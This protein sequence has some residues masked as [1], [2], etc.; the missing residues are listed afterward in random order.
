MA[1]S[2]GKNLLL[3]IPPEIRNEI[4]R[5]L[6]KRDSQLHIRAPSYIHWHK[7]EQTWRATGILYVF[8]QI[9]DEAITIFFEY[10]TF[11]VSNSTISP[12]WGA[13]SKAGFEAFV[14]WIPESKRRLIRN[15][16]LKVSVY[17]AFTG[18]GVGNG[19]GITESF[20]PRD[21]AREMGVL[22]LDV[23]GKEKLL[24]IYGAVSS[25]VVKDDGVVKLLQLHT[26]SLTYGQGREGLYLG[27][28]SDISAFRRFYEHIGATMR[29]LKNV[30]LY[31]SNEEEE[32]DTDFIAP[33]KEVAKRETVEG[34]L[35]ALDHF[36]TMC[37][38]ENVSVRDQTTRSLWEF[39]MFAD[40]V[41]ETTPVQEV[42]ELF[43]KRKEESKAIRFTDSNRELS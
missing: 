7:I 11:V 20:R 29:G 5:L 23:N 10:N 24:D 21:K 4:Y 12:C 14:E 19:I 32:S 6:L 22:G 38:V 34:L 41:E 31:C 27:T 17:R 3:S 26:A 8:K 35:N 13:A 18:I 30:T 43:E 2:S 33:D 25:G 36:E 1:K 9:H 40:A 28:A 39:W 42:V 16:V 37:N 15:L